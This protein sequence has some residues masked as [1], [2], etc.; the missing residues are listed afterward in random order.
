MLEAAW[1]ETSTMLTQIHEFNSFLTQVTSSS[2]KGPCFLTND[3]SNRAAQI[4]AAKAYMAEL[5]N[6]CAHSEAIEKN[7]NLQV[8]VP[9]G[10]ARHRP[11]KDKIGIEGTFV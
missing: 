5:C 6:Q 4:C 10:G 7:T 9:S 2:N 1:D 3:R 11:V 8:F